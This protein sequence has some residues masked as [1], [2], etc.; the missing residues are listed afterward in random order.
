V[1]KGKRERDLLSKIL[2]EVILPTGSNGSGQD[3]GRKKENRETSHGDLLQ[4]FE[5]ETE[6]TVPE[7]REGRS[8]GVENQKS[9]NRNCPRGSD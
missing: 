6:Y 9:K 8:R 2:R 5:Q 4:P 3:S 1:F 7:Y